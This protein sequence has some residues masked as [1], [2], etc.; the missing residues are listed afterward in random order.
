MAVS[1]HPLDPYGADRDALI[2]F[3]TG[4]EFPFH[5][6]PRLDRAAA[7]AAIDAGAYGDDDHAAFWLQVPSGERIGTVRLDDLGDPTPLVDLRLDGGMRGRGLGTKALRAT[8]DFVFDSMAAVNRF[9]GQTREDNTAM[10]RVFALRMGQGGPLPRGLARAGAGTRRVR[11]VCD[12][13]ARLER[14][15]DDARALGGRTASSVG[16]QAESPRP[17]GGWTEIPALCA[18]SAAAARELTP[19]LR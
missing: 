7:L 10:R 18:M 19:S 1:L 6:A 5:V 13:P 2:D 4:N 9:E 8:T 3:L 14:R 15:H 17:D 16:R 11:R 12:T